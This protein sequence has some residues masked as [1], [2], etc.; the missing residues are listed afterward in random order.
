MNICF[1]GPSRGNCLTPCNPSCSYWTGPT[2]PGFTGS[3]VQNGFLYFVKT[4]GTIIN[5][6]YVIGPPGP[7]GATGSTGAQ[8]PTGACL[9]GPTGADGDVIQYA[10]IDDTCN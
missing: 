1:T 2:G 9:T 10:T 6:G 5:S 8:G 3:Y 7:Q 4:D